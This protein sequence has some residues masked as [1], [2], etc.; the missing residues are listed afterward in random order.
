MIQ[1][2]AVVGKREHWFVLTDC[3]ATQ[4]GEKRFVCIDTLLISFVEGNVGLYGTGF[5][6]EEPNDEPNH[7]TTTSSI[8]IFNKQLSLSLSLIW[9]ALATGA[10]FPLE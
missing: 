8:N 6:F 1:A 2:K 5:S 4:T 9:V 7:N 10:R 3:E